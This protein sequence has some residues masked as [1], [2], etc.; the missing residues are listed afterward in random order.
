MASRWR[1]TVSFCRGVKCSGIGGRSLIS[2]YCDEAFDS[3]F[4]LTSS[5]FTGC[6]GA[7][8]RLSGSGL[9]KSWSGYTSLVFLSVLGDSPTC[10]GWALN[11]SGGGNRV[12]TPLSI[13]LRV[14]TQFARFCLFYLSGTEKASNFGASFPK[15]PR[16]LKS[17][18]LLYTVS[19]SCA[20]KSGLLSGYLARRRCQN[21][22]SARLTI[23]YSLCMFLASRAS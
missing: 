13:P 18:I 20:I 10:G 14:S 23:L 9:G 22:N 3:I 6:V 21:S 5:L 16:L 15:I 4:E 8:R 1:N 2:T 12:R 17:F 7:A 11:G 19:T